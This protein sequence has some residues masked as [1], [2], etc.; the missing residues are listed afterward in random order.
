MVA[1]HAVTAILAGA[2][3]RDRARENPALPLAL[4]A[5]T[6]YGAATALRLG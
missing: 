6:L 5:K 2:G 4:A 1:T 3:G